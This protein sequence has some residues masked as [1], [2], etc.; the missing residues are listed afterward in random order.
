MRIAVEQVGQEAVH[1]LKTKGLVRFHRLPRASYRGFADSMIEG[2][3]QPECDERN[4]GKPD[5]TSGFFL[6][7]QGAGLDSF[8]TWRNFQEN[9]GIPE[10]ATHTFAPLAS[11]PSNP[12]RKR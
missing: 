3:G 2:F 6:E 11:F 4:I 5:R 1:V 12:L 7:I 10:G 9:E 8:V